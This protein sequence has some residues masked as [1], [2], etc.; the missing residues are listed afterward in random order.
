MEVLEISF[1]LEFLLELEQ[2]W[3]FS[4][5]RMENQV[6]GFIFSVLF[7]LLFSLSSPSSMPFD[8]KIRT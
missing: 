7:F 4:G 8:T 2:K 1:L 3:I 5:S 6:A